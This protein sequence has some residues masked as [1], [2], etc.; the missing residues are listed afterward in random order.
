M[1]YYTFW[2]LKYICCIL[3]GNRLSLFNEFVSRSI[4]IHSDNK[5]NVSTSTLHPYYSLLRL[6]CNNYMNK[7]WN[8]FYAQLLNNL[9]D[10]KLS[11]IDK[12]LK[13]NRRWTFFSQFK[14]YYYQLII[15]RDNEISN[16][17]LNSWIK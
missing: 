2:W 10:R 8:D 16:I 5:K 17:F 12:N 9:N 6:R 14:F 3:A 13:P 4:Y 15:S 7:N 1:V 11:N